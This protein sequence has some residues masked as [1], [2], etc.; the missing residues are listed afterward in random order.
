MSTQPLRIAVQKS[1]RLLDESIELLRECGI[2]IDNGRDQLKA[3]ARN[4]PVEVLYLRNSD[5]PQYIQ[6]GVADIGILGENTIIEKGKQVDIVQ[7]LGFSKCRLSVAT[8]KGMPYAGLATLQGKR[9]ATS[10]PNS[11]RAY[12]AAN[13]IEAEIHEI[14]GS[15]EIAP[16]IGLADAICDLVSSGSTLF[17]NGLEE[18][19]VVLR[20]EA[21]IAA[22]PR[23]D[24]GRRAILDQL[25]FRVKAVLEAR[26]KKYLLMNV[27]TAKLPDVTRLLP[28]MRS[29]TVLPLAEEG[30]SSVHTVIAEDRFWDII[31][32][33]RAAG[34]EGILIVPI[35]KMIL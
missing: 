27:P 21:V 19:E 31:D 8:P 33:L 29:P 32:T 1:G 23:M 9:I 18:Q 35:D 28:G 11:L 5:I 30:W 13:A 34:A 7:Q 25:L 24:A 12:L 15:V 4:F 20:S 3:P 22:S 14:S 2:K 16:N 17:K 6:D 10:Y 26:N